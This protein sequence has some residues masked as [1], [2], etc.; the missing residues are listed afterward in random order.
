MNREETL[1][2]LLADHA[3]H[4]PN[5]LA[6]R[7]KSLGIWNE[8][9]WEDYYRTVKEL[10]IVLSELYHVEKGEAVAI[11]GENTPKWLFTQMGILSIGGISAGIFPEVSTNQLVYY[12]QESQPRIVFAE[13]QEQVDKLL[14]IEREIPFVEHIIYFNNQGM[15]HYN[16][17]KIL[18]YENLIH[19]GRALLK[20]EEAFLQE[21][22]NRIHT[23]DIAII[24][25]TSGTTGP[26]KGIKVTH[27][28][29]LTA[30]KNLDSSDPIKVKDDYFSL[31]SLSW[32]YEQIMSITMPLLKGLVVNFPEKPNTVLSDMREIAPHIF[33]AHPRVYE[34]FESN[35]MNRLERASHFKKRLYRFF[36]RVGRRIANNKFERKPTSFFDKFVYYVGDWLIFSA[37]RDHFG[38]SRVKQAYIIGGTL[39]ARVFQTFHSIGVNLKQTYGG[40]EFGGIISAHRNDDIRLGTAGPPLLNI[41]IKI[42]E[43]VI[44]LLDKE[45][46]MMTL[47]DRG[48]ID[49]DGHLHI[50][51]RTEDTFTMTNGETV[52]PSLIENKL[53]ESMYLKEVV[54]IGRDRPYLTAILTLQLE[55]LTQ[56]ADENGISYTN[57][58]EL[59][60]NEEVVKLIEEEVQSLME[61]VPQNSRVKKF[62]ILHKSLTVQNEELTWTYRVR[63]PIIEE[64]YAS[65]IDGMYSDRSEVRLV[66]KEND[67]VESNDVSLRVVQFEVSGEVG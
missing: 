67:Q 24:S 40:T 53:K 38:F 30:A 32:I 50:Q 7:Y 43:G 20:T 39:N 16:H 29:L 65:I 51:E 42:E 66:E 21:Q 48:S 17:S 5:E 9:T 4:R 15:R 35:L 3:H 22:L 36:E 37:V 13:D 2:G 47:G 63:R 52:H 1:P 64:K 56:W 59:T 11:I 57:D 28:Q 33:M 14:E 25:F 44:Y 49:E 58:Y 26:S 8:Y 61:G 10:A 19:K 55:R 60:R 62:V 23:D 45:N 6:F 46:K 27:S 31:L 54:C 34:T 18:D 12:L 41:N